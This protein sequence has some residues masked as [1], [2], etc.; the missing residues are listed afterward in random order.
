MNKGLTTTKSS[1]ANYEKSLPKPVVELIFTRLSEFYGNR[2]SEMWKG[3]GSDSLKETWGRELAGY[4]L[5]EIKTGIETCRSKDFPPTLP[6]FLKACRPQI[7][8]ERAFVEA[9]NEYPKRKHGTDKW[10]HPAIFWAA[11][12][13]GE[14]DMSRA[15]WSSI[16]DRW[17][18]E[19]SER[20]ARKDLPEI[21]LHR[22]AIS[23]PEDVPVSQEEGRRRCEA[24]KR[25]LSRLTQQQRMPA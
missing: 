5:E 9:A 16:K 11:H 25:M 21:P 19:L 15:S 8:V 3:L 2:F 7:D 1:T 23:A 10:T 24:L 12:A 6:E 4:S 22:E 13:I 20:L 18:R 14:F 17:K